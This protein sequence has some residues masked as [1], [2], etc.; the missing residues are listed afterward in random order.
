MRELVLAAI[1]IGFMALFLMVPETIPVFENARVTVGFGFLLVT[2]YIIGMFFSRIN[3]PKISGY[4]LAG[5]LFG[6]QALKFFDQALISDMSIINQLALTFIALNAGGELKLKELKQQRKVLMWLLI[7]LIALISTVMLGMTFLLKPLIPFLRDVSFKET[8]AVGMLLGVLG[9]ARSPSS[10]IAIIQEFRAKGPFSETVLGATVVIDFLVILMFAVVVSFS[11]TLL[12][13]GQGLDFV[14]FAAV[15]LEVIISSLSGV[16]IGAGVAY[17]INKVKVNVP[18]ILLVLAF[19]IY[20][21]SGMISSF[22]TETMQIS[23]HL[24]PLLA[25]ITAGFYIQNFTKGGPE[26]IESIERSSLPVYVLFF[27]IA[28]LV[29]D[30][31]VMFNLIHV[32]V[33]LFLA[34]ATTAVISGRIAGKITNSPEMHSKMFGL[35]FITQAG[36][37]IGLAQEIIRR[38][39]E[40]GLPLGTLII[41]VININQIVG[42]ISFKYALGKVGEIRTK[43]KKT[44]D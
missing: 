44:N 36:V 22:I 30:I 19:L 20:N 39:P 26:F 21:V 25:A 8:L 4:L 41:S 14:F 40:W 37:S 27:S 35:G 9:I 6:P 10:I 33:L 42:P 17:Y 31:E 24:E 5:M 11:Q 23:F 29:L 34:R 13:P 32:A 1:V 43:Q 3:L 15:G 18:I 7:M 16:A 2:S 38:F 12:N 28:G